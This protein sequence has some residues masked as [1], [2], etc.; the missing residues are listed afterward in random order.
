MSRMHQGNYTARIGNVTLDRERVEGW[1][2]EWNA[3][4]DC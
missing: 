4:L 1:P 2:G 3:D